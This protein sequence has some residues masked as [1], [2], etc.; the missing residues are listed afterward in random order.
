MQM[1]LLLKR[2]RKDNMNAYDVKKE[3]KDAYGVK[4]K[5]MRITLSKASYLK[6]AG[7][8]NPNEKDVLMQKRCVYYMDCNIQLR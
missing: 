3:M 4:T 7:T 2:E 1:A 6:I 8:G 5:P